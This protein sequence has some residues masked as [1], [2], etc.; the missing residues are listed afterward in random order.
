M[1][2]GDIQKLESNISVA[3]NFTRGAYTT[4]FDR[5]VSEFNL[6]PQVGGIVSQ[7]GELGASWTS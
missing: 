6:L 7:P 2:P 1:G 4:Y 3:P 5:T